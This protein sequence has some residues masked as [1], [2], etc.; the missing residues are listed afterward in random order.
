MNKPEKRYL[1]NTNLAY[2]L[3]TLNVNQRN[4]RVS[5]I[6]NQLVVNSANL[7]SM[8]RWAALLI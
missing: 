4:A 3:A 2:C 8:D 6:S 1:D 7:I 5:H